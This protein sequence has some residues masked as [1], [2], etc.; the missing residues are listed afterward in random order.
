V[1]L[2]RQREKSKPMNNFTNKVYIASKDQ[3]EY[4]SLINNAQLDDLVITQ[5]LPT[6][7]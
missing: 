1:Y 4:A 6:S 5:A 2:I 7:F 3:A